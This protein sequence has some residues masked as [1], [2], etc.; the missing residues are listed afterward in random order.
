ML[1]T[2]ILRYLVN[3]YIAFFILSSLKPDI[4]PQSKDK[5]ATWP[6]PV[7]KHLS[8]ADGLP[9]NSVLCV[10]QDHLGYMWF[11]TQ[12]G[13]VKYDGYSL[14]IYQ[15]EPD[16]SLSISDRRIFAIYEDRSGTLWIGTEHED[17]NRFDRATETFTR[18]MLSP[19]DSTRGDSGDNIL[20]IYEDNSGD[21]LVGTLRGLTLFNKETE[22]FK[23]INYQGQ[24]YSPTVYEY[25]SSLVVKGNRISSILQVG[26]NVNLTK[27]F[28]IDKTTS[29][30]IVTMGEAGCD[31]GWLENVKGEII[32]GKNYNNTVCAGGKAS[33]QIRVVI[34]T[35][36]EGSYRLHYISDPQQSYNDW[37]NSQPDYPDFWGIQVIELP[38]EQRGV[39]K[40]LNNIK[41]TTLKYKASAIIEDSVSGNLYIGTT[42]RILVFNSKKQ[43]L[44][45][46]IGIS[47]ANSDVSDIHSFYQANDGTIWIG[48]S[49]GL[50]RFNPKD[51]SIKL[52]Q[53]TPSVFYTLDND[54][55]K[56]TEDND[57]F[58]WSGTSSGPKGNGLIGFNPKNEQFKIY[59]NIPGKPESLSSDVVR[60]VYQ[61][62]SGIMLVGTGWA[63][64]NKWN[65]SKDKFKH[66]SYDSNGD[67]LNSV[68]TVVE[69]D[70]GIIWL[71]TDNGLY[72]FNRNSN[73]FWNYKYDMKSNNN[74]VVYIYLDGSGIIWFAT[75]TRGL[76]KF[77]RKND[78]F[79]FYTNNPS[80]SMSLSLNHITNI[81]PD[82]K[83][84]LWIG[85]WGGGLNR[86][87]KKTGKFTRFMHDPDN[88][89]SVSRDQ[90]T[91]MYND[92]RG[93]LWIGTGGNSLNHF[94]R[95]NESFKSFQIE[96]D[97]TTTIDAVYEDHKNNFWVGTYQTGLYLFD[98]KNGK[99]VYNISVKDGLS[100]DDIGS[101]LEDDSGNLWI[102][103]EYGLSK[104]DPETRKTRNYYISDVFEENSYIMAGA[105]KTSTG[106]MLFGTLDGFIMF[107]PDSIKD[108]PVP[109]QVVI[110]NV[111]L[112]NRS[113]E[114]LEIDGFISEMK[115][116]DLSYDENDL[117]FDYLGL[118]FADPSKNRY[119]YRLEG[120]DNDWVDAGTQ[121]SA[122]YTNLNAGEYVFKVTA[123]NEDGVWNK[124]GASIK[125]IIPPPFWETWWAYSLYVLL[126]LVLLYSIR[127]Y[128]LNRTNLKNQVKLDAVKLKEREETDKMKSRFFANI[129]HEF[130]TPLTLILGPIEK[131]LSGLAEEETHKQANLVKRNANRLLVLINQLLDLSRL[132]A[133]KLE[134]KASKSNVV[135]FIKGITMS[136]ES[137][138]ERKDITL[139][140]EAEKDEIELY[141]DKEKMMKIMTNLLSNAFKFTPE[142]GAITVSINSPTPRP[143]KGGDRTLLKV[144]STGGDLGVGQ[145]RMNEFVSISVHDT[146]IGISEEELPKLFDR[147]YQVDSSQTREYEGTGLGLALTKELVELHHGTINVTSEVGIGTK[148]TIELP[149]GRRHLKDEEVLEEETE[150]AVILNEVKNLMENNAADSSYF[151]L[152]DRLAGK[153]SMTEADNEVGEDKNIVLV[154]EDNADVRDFII[155]S[156]GNDFKIEEAANGE[157]GV[158]K[159]EQI[160]PDLIISDIMMPKM[161]GNE[162]TRKIKNDERTSHIPVILLTA[163]SE[164]ESRLEG[165]ETGADDYLIKPFDSKEL[166]IR[167]KNLIDTRRRLQ[168]KYSR[169]D[170]IWKQDKKKLSN[171]DEQF[172]NRVMEV[173]EKHLN[174]EEFSI[175]IFDKEVGIG[176][177]QN[178]RK[179]KA[180]TGCSPSRYI[181]KVRLMKARQMIK[182]KRGNISDIAYSVGF[183]S[184]TYFTRCFKK[185]FGY[186]PKEL[187]K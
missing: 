174:E 176:R 53:P 175:E 166:R 46:E 9:E 157:Q 178:Y 143:S 73:E 151:D 2:N 60:S 50:S 82:G 25:I 52:Y 102:G 129:S 6:E 16:D 77:D 44:I 84:V 101:I 140:V 8:I 4:L 48:H 167:I 29:A 24:V 130:R 112:F 183:S 184:P 76:G 13:L 47:E 111:S 107:H 98:R 66:F 160:I 153:L 149:V 168:E 133:G 170:N 57:G 17:L 128:E 150:S 81:L 179:L 141:F 181:R 92:R 91:I 74:E 41:T 145:I 14:K 182:E 148:F 152:P 78:S 54:I 65:K 105:C 55:G 187:E 165:L 103:T 40:I 97:K 172:M 39:R 177:V 125:I 31:Y 61:D 117:R 106:E 27:T 11:G 85:T 36:L 3:F 87:D 30:L 43:S 109:P 45:D 116:L 123:C 96:E 80:D 162:L 159:A 10:L 59:K 69:D 19:E 22:K 89:K 127:R 62:H 1:K 86:F 64:L 114:K 156:L 122:T 131:I 124:E 20:S 135:S 42:G 100:N 49:M 115:E 21:L 88:P 169:G 158:R 147:F 99:P 154:V 185:E 186:L 94:D 7:F 28:T 5:T 134:L 51:N 33:Y 164:Q 110:S 58:I 56:I 83:D 90:I 161:D 138:A 70:H 15:P 75:E 93:N 23:H 171:L 95:T 137:V 136:F 146:G 144:P 67:R 18:Y 120:F 38:E 32:K 72:S 121:R 118:H 132:E 71:G 108:D 12:N 79:Y 139:K 113:G 126:G 173:I 34:D 68:W 37:I 119:K 163:K 104:F 155:D 180:L 26:N 35:L 142:G 63:G